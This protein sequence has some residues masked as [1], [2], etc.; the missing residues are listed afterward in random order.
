LKARLKDPAS[1]DRSALHRGGNRHPRRV[2][3]LRLCAEEDLIV[4]VQ[5]IYA[6]AAIFVAVYMVAALLR[7]DK[8]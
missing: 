7:P 1:H 3:P 6:A 8:F 4:I 2:R 5:L